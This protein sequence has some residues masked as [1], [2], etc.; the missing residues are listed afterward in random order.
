MFYLGLDLEHMIEYNGVGIL[1]YWES[2]RSNS[3]YQTSPEANMAKKLPER[4]QKVLDCIAQYRDEHGFPPT[5]REIG[6]SIGVNSTS[7]VTYYLKRLEEKG[8]IIREPSM[9]RAI[10][11]TETATQ[12]VTITVSDDELLPVPF[13]GYI[14][15]GVPI[16]VEALAGSETIEINRALFGRDISDL[17][18]LRV[19]GNS[20]ID[21]LVNDGDIVVLK[22]QDRVENGQMAAIW[23][24]DE[25][26]TTLKKVYNEGQE[27]RLQPANPTMGP[28]MVPADQVQVQGK[29]VLVIR[30]LQ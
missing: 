6:N 10:Q 22:H 7:L 25:E 5:V 8:L 19:Q 14:A 23:L 28:I 20:M 2:P 15:A 12:Q 9:S 18:A 1:G 30:Q 13:L 3:I 26:S 24:V 4:Q 21:A 17:Y 11:L 16:N 27:I 29:V